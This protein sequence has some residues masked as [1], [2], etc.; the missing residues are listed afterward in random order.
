MSPENLES[1]DSLERRTRSSVAAEVAS[2]AVTEAE[3]V[4]VAVGAEVESVVVAVAEAATKET[5]PEPR[6]LLSEPA[7]LSSEQ[8]IFCEG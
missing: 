4:T 3:E 1:P 6:L 2:V 5:R 7:K 8:S